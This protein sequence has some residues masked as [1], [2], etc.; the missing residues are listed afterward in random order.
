M[1]KYVPYDAAVKAKHFTILCTRR[2]RCCSNRANLELLQGISWSGSGDKP[3]C[4]TGRIR[5]IGWRRYFRPSSFSM[6]EISSSSQLL[7][8]MA[9]QP[10]IAASMSIVLS[11]VGRN[12]ITLRPNK[13]AK[14]KS[15]TMGTPHHWR[16]EKQYSLDG[17][18]VAIS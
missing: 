8:T 9:A 7:M 16:E 6:G 12:S 14:A 3:R 4:G 13:I 17:S 10:A 11:L 18:D 15:G 2:R 5:I 1:V